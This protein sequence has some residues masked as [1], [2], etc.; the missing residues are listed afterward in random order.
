MAFF[1]GMNH[2]LPTRRWD[3]NAERSPLLRLPPELRERIWQYVLGG[4]VLHIGRKGEFGHST[5]FVYECKAAASEKDLARHR[6]PYDGMDA[7]PPTVPYFVRHTPCETSYH[8][9]K[10]QYHAT[11]L[12]RTCRL[13]HNDAALL[14]FS[15][16]TFLITE[17]HHHAALVWFLRRLKPEQRRAIRKLV[18]MS[19]RATC[20]PQEPVE[21]DFIATSL[22]G[23]RDLTYI[24]EFNYF[25]TA[26]SFLEGEHRERECLA[27]DVLAFKGIA[28]KTAQV[29]VALCFTNHAEAALTYGITDVGDPRREWEASVLKQLM[30]RSRE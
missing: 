18:M 25:G 11:Y 15:E 17:L 30:E 13:I 23:L 8:L 21:P 6:G 10:A 27:A 28:L 2:T 22:I 14:P 20:G 5:A 24:V 9:K 7:T 19:C 16:N 4:K 29:N 26:R 3:T 1:N 12:L